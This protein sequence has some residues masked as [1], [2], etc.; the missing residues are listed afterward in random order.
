MKL[1]RHTIRSGWTS[2]VPAAST[3]RYSMDNGDF[4][5]NM[6]LVELEIFPIS[7]DMSAGTMD[8]LSSENVFFVVATSERGATPIS[9][10]FSP[11]EYGPTNNLRPSDSS[12][13]AWGI[14]TP[15]YAYVYT[16]ID[17]DHIIPEDLY[18][19]AWSNAADGSIVNT[20]FNLGYCMVFEQVKNTGSEALLYQV[21]E[22]AAD[23][24]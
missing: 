16:H 17:P 10:T 12:Q 20:Y 5:L 9:G 11:E 18:I 13:I 1:G 21:K 2:Q 4:Q 14:A 3:R 23:E 15:A 24:S 22:T 19:S 8:R 7:T 6:K